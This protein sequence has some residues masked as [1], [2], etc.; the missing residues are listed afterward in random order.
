MNGIK[1]VHLMVCEKDDRVELFT[2]DTKSNSVGRMCYASEEDDG[3]CDE[4]DENDEENAPANKTITYFK[5]VKRGDW[6]VV[7]YDSKLYPGKVSNKGENGMTVNVMK[8]CF[9]SGWTWPCQR[10]EIF[11]L[12]ENIAKKI[13]PPYPLNSRGKWGFNNEII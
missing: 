9:P 3:Q 13:D 2:D 10:D 6:V 1:S 4:S 5:S 8:P 11:Y 7:R 12:F